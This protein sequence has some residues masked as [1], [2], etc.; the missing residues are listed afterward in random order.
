[1][2]AEGHAGAVNQLFCLL[3]FSPLGIKPRGG[4]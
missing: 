4:G 2:R 3:Q 1:V